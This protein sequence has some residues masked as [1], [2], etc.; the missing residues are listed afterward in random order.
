MTGP[1]PPSPGSDTRIYRLPGG[2]PRLRIV[3]GLAGAAGREFALDTPV[4]TIG[5]RTDQTIVL[6]DPSVSRAHARI[7]VGPQGVEISDLGSTNGT[8]VNRL[9]LRAGRAML[10]GGDRIEIGTV[11][12]EYLAPS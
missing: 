5:R 1:L 2:S 3:S 9:P 8:R 12:L 4:V 7:E 6:G 11:V 10:R